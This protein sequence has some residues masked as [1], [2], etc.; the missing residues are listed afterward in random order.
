MKT[1]LKKITLTLAALALLALPLAAFGQV[2]YTPYVFTT[3]AGSAGLTGSA[4]GIGSAAR[5]YEPWGVAVDTNGTVYVAD[6]GNHT[7]RKVT[8]AG[9]V[10]TLAGLAGSADSLNGTGAAAR[11]YFPDALAVDKAGNVYVAD[12]YN[13]TIRKV[14]PAGV[15]TTLAG[16][17]GF[18]GSTDGSGSAARFA[19]TR[20]LT[21]DRAGNVYVADS[22][23]HTIRKGSPSLFVEFTASP[24]LGVVPLYVQFT[25]P[26]TD[27]TGKAI[28][29]WNWTFGDGSTST[30]QNP[31]HAYTTLGTYQPSLW[32]TN[33]SGQGVAG[34]GPS[35]T[36]AAYLDLV[37]NG[38][39]ESG[40]F[41]GWTL[42]GTAAPYN[43]VDTFNQSTEGMQSH[44][45]SSYFARLGQS[46]SLGYLS[47]TLATTP[48]AKY[49]L[50]FWLN[51]PDGL[52]P[53]Q[54]LVSWR[55][56]QI[57]FRNNLP[58]F[59][60]NPA[61]AWSNL[62]FT[63]TATASATVLQFGFRDDPTALGLDDICVVQISPALA[64]QPQSQIV[65]CQSNAT[66]TAI[67]TGPPPLS[68][69]WL[70]CCPV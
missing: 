5:F 54:F 28:T 9:V 11:F 16:L 36:A 15:V 57:Y 4:N 53:N 8:P 44:A 6:S 52:T 1:I 13:N 33:N 48:G 63:V 23:N 38:G 67:A 35:V 41:L 10:T 56:S 7:I 65:T 24:N 62:Q 37:S 29:N 46:G 61:I 47:Q 69:Q 20:G 60:N 43:L 30:A 55:G 27:S 40:N 64:L 70:Q 51:S 39:F 18:S 49:L 42:T 32:V 31:S 25:C 12:T 45:P 34:S 2:I 17:A 21:V 19:G 66:F 26:D 22:D 68:Y 50:S 58:A 3:L 59:G 14:T